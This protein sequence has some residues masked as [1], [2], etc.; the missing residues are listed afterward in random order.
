M[1][2]WKLPAPLHDAKRFE[3]MLSH[4]FAK[5][6]DALDR[7]AEIVA[8]GPLVFSRRFSWHVGDADHKTVPGKSVCRNFIGVVASTS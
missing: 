3:S 5:R 7:R 4:V 2:A 6:L 1:R 8:D